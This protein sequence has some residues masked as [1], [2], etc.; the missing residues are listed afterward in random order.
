[1]NHHSKET[2]DELVIVGTAILFFVA[3]YDTTSTTLAFAL[4]ELSKNPEIQDRLREEVENIS[5]SDTKNDFTYDNLHDMTYLDQIICETLRFYNPTGMIQRT[6]TKEYTIPGSDIIIPKDNNVWVN[7]VAI[8][9]DPKHYFDPHVF[10]PDHF[11]K[12]AKAQRN[13]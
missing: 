4:Y 11:S 5:D 10:N 9:F 8:H 7:T 2:F 3:G 1:M 13:P 6:V 12:E